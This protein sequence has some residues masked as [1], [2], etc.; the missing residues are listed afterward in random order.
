MTTKCIQAYT[1]SQNVS[2]HCQ[3]QIKHLIQNISAFFYILVRCKRE[4]H[5]I[6][7]GIKEAGTKHAKIPHPV[8][9]I[10]LTFSIKNLIPNN[11]PKI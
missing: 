6:K 1:Y 7:F 2:F 9:N 3:R 5:D 8:L 4:K 10:Y 11:N